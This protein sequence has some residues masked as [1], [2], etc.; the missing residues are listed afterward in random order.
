MDCLFEQWSPAQI[1][2]QVGISHETIYCH[3]YAYKAAGG[4]L[5]AVA[6]S[7]KCKKRYAGDRERRGQTIGRRAIVERSVHIETRSQVGHWEDD[8]VI[9]AAHK[10]AI[11]TLVERKSGYTVLAKVKNKTS[12]LVSSAIMTKL[13]PLAPLVKTMIFDNGKE[14]AEYSRIDTALQSTT[15]IADS[16]ASWLRGSNQT[17]MDCCGNTSRK[18]DL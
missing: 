18:R 2:N 17:S 4:S 13:K 5:S 12:D 1:A 8:T 9:G 15:Y 10:Q 3:V 6:L 16:F 14:F 7:K 11:V